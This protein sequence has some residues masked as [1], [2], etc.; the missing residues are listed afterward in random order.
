MKFDF[1]V[2][3]ISDTLFYDGAL[4]LFSKVR[5]KMLENIETNNQLVERL[6]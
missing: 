4:T 6:K 2:E 3:M 5:L 1:F